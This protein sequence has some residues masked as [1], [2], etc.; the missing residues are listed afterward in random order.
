MSGIGWKGKLWRL[1][2][3]LFG[4][5]L[6]SAL[7]FFADL[8]WSARP[9]DPS[10]W[11]GDY[12]DQSSV[13]RLSSGSSYLYSSDGGRWYFSWEYSSGSFSLSFDDGSST[14]L[15]MLSDGDLYLLSAHSVF[16]RVS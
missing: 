15:R 5:V 6:C 8:T 10:G 16:W 14:L 3:L 1:F 13:L 9:S 11:F 12:R 4:A 7:F 2:V